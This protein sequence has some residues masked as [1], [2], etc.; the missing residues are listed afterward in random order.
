MKKL[1]LLTISLLMF[2]IAF[3]QDSKHYF[4]GRIYSNFEWN[5]LDKSNA[6]REV[7]QPLESV[8]TMNFTYGLKL[9]KKMRIEAGITASYFNNQVEAFDFISRHYV[10]APTIKIGYSDSFLFGTSYL[11]APYFSYA[12]GNGNISSNGYD[13]KD[14]TEGTILGIQISMNKSV[15]RKIGVQLSLNIQNERYRNY[16]GTTNNIAL[17][18]EF[19]EIYPS[20]NLT[21]NF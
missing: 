7:K 21:H 16:R 11:I 2:S 17:K 9:Y 19:L 3:S 6:S 5:I 20:I 14:K 18:K 8:N 13:S 12:I 1:I 4:T 15:Y 10:L